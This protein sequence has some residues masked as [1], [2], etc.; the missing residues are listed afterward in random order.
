MILQALLYRVTISLMS[1]HRDFQ[2]DEQLDGRTNRE[3]TDRGYYDLA[4]TAPACIMVHSNKSIQNDDLSTCSKIH[5][6]S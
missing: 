3:I 6:H 5:A 2:C 1:S 4:Y